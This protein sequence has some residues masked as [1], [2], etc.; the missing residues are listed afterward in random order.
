MIEKLKPQKFIKGFE[1]R[2]GAPIHIIN[3]NGKI[4]A[5]SDENSMGAVNVKALEC[6]ID[7]GGISFDDYSGIYIPLEHKGNPFGVINIKGDCDIKRQKGLMIKDF[8]EYMAVDEE[9]KE[10]FFEE[11]TNLFFTRLL[12]KDTNDGYELL[13]RRARQLKINY[14]GKYIVSMKFFNYKSLKDENIEAVKEF[15]RIQLGY[16]LWMEDDKLYLIGSACGSMDD[17]LNRLVDHLKEKF[18]VAVTFIYSEICKSISDYP[19]QYRL[20]RK[21]SQFDYL[22]SLDETVHSIAEKKPLCFLENISSE[23]LT[24]YTLFFRELYTDFTEGKNLELIY[25]IKTYFECEMSMKETA[26]RLFVHRNTI[27][28]RFGLIKDLYNIDVTQLRCCLE[29]YLS[30]VSMEILRVRT[31]NDVVNSRDSVYNKV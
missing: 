31:K 2:V 23:V 26:E 10:A 15:L 7:K 1:E 5:A 30:I 20:V 12:T 4:V 16:I 14:K 21:V 24:D 25:T 11:S 6:L 13:A 28:Y 3:P 8:F 27:R 19:A 9:K 22:A 29:V 18:G 17:K